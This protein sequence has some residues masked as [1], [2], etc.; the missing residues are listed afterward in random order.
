MIKTSSLRHSVPEWLLLLVYER[1]SAHISPVVSPHSVLL[2]VQHRRALHPSLLSSAD[3]R[4]RVSCSG[5]YP[6]EAVSKF[7]LGRVSV[8]FRSRQECAGP[9]RLLTLGREFFWCPASS[10]MV[11]SLPAGYAGRRRGFGLCCNHFFRRA[12]CAID[13]KKDTTD[14][15]A[16]TSLDR[17]SPFWRSLASSF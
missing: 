7:G 9:C 3:W 1:L 5:P 6:K 13:L 12:L 16:S 15:L 14:L 8:L 2:A 17:D 4:D 11:A 10:R